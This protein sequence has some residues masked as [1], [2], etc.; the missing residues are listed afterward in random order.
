MKKEQLKILK[1][2][3]QDD[4]LKELKESKDRLWQ[5]RVD[6]VAGKVK[7]VQEIR[8]LKKRIAAINTII[9]CHQ[10]H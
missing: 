3:S 10:R 6:L 7:N 4:L 8:H 5:L 2:K 9:I 1:E